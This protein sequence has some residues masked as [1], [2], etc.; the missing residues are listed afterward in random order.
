MLPQKALDVPFAIL[1]GHV[2]YVG[3]GEVREVRQHVDVFP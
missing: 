1:H 2:E 3:A